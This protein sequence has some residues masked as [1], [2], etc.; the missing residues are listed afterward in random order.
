MKAR[1]VILVAFACAISLLDAK[2]SRSQVCI[3]GVGCINES[4][5]PEVTMRSFNIY[6]KNRSSHPISACVEYYSKHNRATPDGSGT[7]WSNGC[8]D[9]APG[10]KVFVIDDASGR[11]AYFSAEAVDGSGLTW[12]RKKVDMGST[13]T[14]FEFTFE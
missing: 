7:N 8:W 4:G 3:P 5:R 10:K 9:V 14:R 2:P 13:Y 11:Y 12:G 6:L 1:R